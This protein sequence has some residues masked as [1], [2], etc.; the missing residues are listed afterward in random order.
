[1]NGAEEP[2]V[3]SGQAAV[4]TRKSKPNKADGSLARLWG[5]KIDVDEFNSISSS[6]EQSKRSLIVSLSLAK[7]AAADDGR[8][9]D[10]TADHRPEIEIT[11]TPSKAKNEALPRRSPRNHNQPIHPMFLPKA[12]RKTIQKSYS[13]LSTQSDLATSDFGIPMTRTASRDSSST[14]LIPF[15]AAGTSSASLPFPELQF[16]AESGTRAKLSHHYHFSPRK[17]KGKSQSSAID[18]VI[19]AIEHIKRACKNTPRSFKVPSKMRTDHYQ[20]EKDWSYD[21]DKP[22]TSQALLRKRHTKADIWPWK[23]RPINSSE[24]VCAG[25]KIDSLKLWLKTTRDPNSKMPAVDKQN[26]EADDMN[27][28][29]VDSESEDDITR[30]YTRPISAEVHDPSQDSKETRQEIL[31]ATS[32]IVVFGKHGCGKSA[33][34]YAVAEELGY[35]IVEINGSSRRSGKDVE[36]QF[37]DLT[38]S[39]LIQNKGAKLKPIFLLEDVEIQFEQDKGFWQ[40]VGVIIER[41]RWPV[42]LTTS[43]EYTFK[44]FDSYC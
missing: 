8:S 41:S 20:L 17:A 19:G 15:H 30:N 13:E 35:Q 26:G 40:A 36:R 14:T 3:V 31:L 42:I 25:K 32:S 34:I 28:F 43:G 27:S 4:P 2:P 39:T 16:V 21:L 33:A 38:Q 23:Y 12:Q 11:S 9:F 10:L 44:I 29:I 37:G 5:W 24:I 7:E 1:M 6:E 22:A 18:K